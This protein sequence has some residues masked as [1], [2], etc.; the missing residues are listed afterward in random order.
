M[1]EAGIIH[2]D[3]CCSPAADN[4]GHG[5]DAADGVCQVENSSYFPLASISFMAQ[6]LMAAAITA[7]LWHILNLTEMGRLKTP[8]ASQPPLEWIHCWQF[9]FRSVGQSRAPSLLL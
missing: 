9:L 5:H 3:E 7:F 8:S 1:E 4:H 6:L 2:Y